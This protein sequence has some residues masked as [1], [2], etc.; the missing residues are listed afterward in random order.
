[1]NLTPHLPAI[2]AARFTRWLSLDVRPSAFR[3]M[4]AVEACE[5]G[6]FRDLKPDRTRQH[7][8]FPDFRVQEL[9]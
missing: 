4:S 7:A 2:L 8:E 5:R 3:C 9:A 1:M 6:L